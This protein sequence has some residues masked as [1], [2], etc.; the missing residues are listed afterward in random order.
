MADTRSNAFRHRSIYYPYCYR[1]ATGLNRLVLTVNPHLQPE[2]SYLNNTLDIP[3]FVQPDTFGPLL[4]VAF[5]GTRITNGSVVSA[6]PQID[7]LV[8]DENRSLIRHDTTGLDLY[9]QR[10]GKNELFERLSWKKATVQAAGADNVFRIR[11]PSPPLSDGI[12]HLL[13]TAR[14]AVGNAAVPYQ[15]SFRV[16][17]EPALTNLQVYPNPF[18]AQT[19]FS[20]TL[21]GSQAPDGVTLSLT[22]LNGHIVRHLALPTRIGLNEWPW[23]GRSDAGALLPAGVYTYKLTISN[24]AVWP[25]AAGVTGRLSGRLMLTR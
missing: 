24:P 12:Y 18:Y 20:F 22:D 11:Y 15:V 14:D 1:K 6:R 13:A 19:L 25:V 23:N 16:V 4:E 7:L 5:D 21:T 10:P 3:L 9:L 17:A 8:A 2:Y